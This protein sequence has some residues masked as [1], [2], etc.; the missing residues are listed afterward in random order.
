MFD[1]NALR[2]F[3]A[4]EIKKLTWPL[5]YDE[6]EV[7]AAEWMPE[8]RF[9]EDENFHPISYGQ[10]LALRTAQIRREDFLRTVTAAEPHRPSS[11]KPPVFFQSEDDK[12]S[13]DPAAPSISGVSYMS[14]VV[15]VGDRLSQF[16]NRDR[17]PWGMAYM[18]FGSKPQSNGVKTPAKPVT[19][20]AE[21]RDLR[22]FL[23]FRVRAEKAWLTNQLPL[24]DNGVLDSILGPV[25]FQLSDDHPQKS[26]QLSWLAQLCDLAD[27]ADQGD[28][29]AAMHEA[30]ILREVVSDD[31]LTE[32]QWKVI[33][34]YVLLEYFFVYAYNDITQHHTISSGDHEG[35]VEGFGV[36][37]DRR[38]V[39]GVIGRLDRLDYLRNSL[40]P[41]FLVTA[42]HAQWQGLDHGKD[43]EDPNDPHLANLTLPAFKNEVM[44]AWVMAGSHAMFLC[45]GTFQNFN[46]INEEVKIGSGL[47]P[48]LLNPEFAVPAALLIELLEH[49]LEPEEETSDD[50]VRST[51]TWSSGQPAA[52]PTSVASRVLTTPLSAD[53]NVYQSSWSPGNPAET[54]ITLAERLFPGTWG[55]KTAHS[56]TN[57]ERFIQVLAER[58][59]E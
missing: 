9:D 53:R 50:G 21:Y 13:L 43:L 2:G 27:K 35:D 22:E 40:R 10:L 19:A 24:Y 44:R 29:A 18:Y 36:L 33:R 37:F 57:I 16:D 42:P 32:A 17:S 39:A 6:V 41:R 45:P 28:A 58:F 38:K 30:A 49:F 55:F 14:N 3:G 59:F 46:S 25:W 34:D 4:A 15:E 11:A 47:L 23:A 26:R 7:L 52:V 54:D 20:V 31:V 56:F 48:V 1:V 12:I 51:P 5:T 8:L